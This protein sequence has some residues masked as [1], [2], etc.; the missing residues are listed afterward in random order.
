MNDI[1]KDFSEAP[2]GLKGLFNVSKIRLIDSLNIRTGRDLGNHVLLF[3][4]LQVKKLR[5]KRDKLREE[6][7][8]EIIYQFGGRAKL[9]KS[10]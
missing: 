7:S 4:H 9:S 6:K 10:E 3:F 2:S 5:T 1:Q 8:L